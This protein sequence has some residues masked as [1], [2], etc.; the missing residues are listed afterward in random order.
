MDF[1]TA[2]DNIDGYN[3][4]VYI[5][6]CKI[7]NKKYIGKSKFYVGKDNILRNRWDEHKRSANAN[8]LK[9]FSR[10]IKKYGE[11]NFIFDITDICATEQEAFDLEAYYIKFY[12]T[13]NQSYGYNLTDGGEGVSG[14]RFTDEQRKN[15]SLSHMGIKQSESQKLKKAI[16]NTGQKRSVEQ[17]AKMSKAQKGHPERRTVEGKLR[18]SISV[19]GENNQISKLSN[20]NV[21]EIK[22]K[23][24]TGNY[25]R[26]AL[27][28]E[29]GVTAPAIGDITAGKTW[30]HIIE[31]P[32]IEEIQNKKRGNYKLTD[33]IV[34]K[35]LIK[36]MSGK[37]TQT[38]LG[39]EYNIDRSNIG[40]ILTRKTWQH[41]DVGPIEIIHGKLTEKIVLEIINKYNSGNYTYSKLANEY[42]LTVT[43][44]YNIIKRKTW[45]HV[46]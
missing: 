30:K 15:L 46:A 9:L 21:I 8:N 36:Y 3:F 2:K 18:Q 38:Q 26:E 41:I 5:V 20:E 27:S 19:S 29:Y 14:Y 13:K 6:T 10:A 40:F 25:T 37:Y 39:I 44:I 43:S 24:N 45:K 23:F 11:D 7:N 28:K 42:N 17:R 16:A 35:I 1:D 31:I 32:I 22:K 33:E 12:D 4:Y 34:K